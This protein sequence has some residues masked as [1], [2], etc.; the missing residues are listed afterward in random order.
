M[1]KEFGENSVV[2]LMQA[3]NSE[4]T[5]CGDAFDCD[6][7]AGTEHI[8][9]GADHIYPTKK[10]VVTCERCIREIENCRNVKTMN[11]KALKTKRR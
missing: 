5:I 1:K 10:K 11:T 3:F 7:E 8:Y 4:Y 2:H 9:P 6:S